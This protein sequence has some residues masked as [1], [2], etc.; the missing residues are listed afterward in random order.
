MESEPSTSSKTL[1]NVN[2]R[3]AESPYGLQRRVD[4]AYDDG[5]LTL[6][7]RLPTF[8]LKQTAQAVVARVEGVRQVINLVDVAHSNDGTASAAGS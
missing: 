6:R 8:F 4:G 7:G 2:R 3:L 1:D 5:I